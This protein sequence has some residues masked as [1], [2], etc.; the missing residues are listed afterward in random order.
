L[1]AIA[2]PGRG[3]DG[4]PAAGFAGKRLQHA[5]ASSLVETRHP[6]DVTE[7]GACADEFGQRIL[8][9]DRRQHSHLA[10]RQFEDVDQPFGHD[11]IADADIRI[12]RFRESAE[13]EDAWRRRQPLQRGH[14]TRLIVKFAVIVVLDDAGADRLRIAKQFEA[15]ADRHQP[16]RRILMRRGDEDESRR[17][18]ARADGHALFVKRYRG[19]DGAGGLE[20]DVGAAVARAF[21]PGVI[22]RREQRCRDQRDAGLGRRHDQ[23]LA[24]L[25]LD[26]AMNRQM[27]QQRFLQRRMVDG[28]VPAQQCV[29]RRAPQ[30]TAPKIVWKLTFIRQS[31]LKRPGPLVMYRRPVRPL[32]AACPG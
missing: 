23:D 9:R 26:P 29:S 8:H 12:G 19:D 20:G 25:G 11:D 1:P 10:L 4:K 18:L 13:I 5:V 15:A 28:P 30:A 2:F 6:S 14:R 31:R 27:R 3:L 7:I 24:R 16:P 17:I 32:Q 21:D 22:A